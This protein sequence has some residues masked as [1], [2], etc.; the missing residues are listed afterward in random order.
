MT[1]SE[2]IDRLSEMQQHLAHVEIVDLSG[3]ISDC[4]VEK[5]PT[6]VF[7]HSSALVNSKPVYCGGIAYN[8]Y[9]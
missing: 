1:K 7:A 3:T 6:Q 8:V 9:R 5:L 4:Y 2:L